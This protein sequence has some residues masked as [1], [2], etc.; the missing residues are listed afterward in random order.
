MSQI[1]V[2]SRVN[3]GHSDLVHDVRF[4][5]F[6][7][8]LATCSSD[9]LIK[10]FQVQKD[11]HAGQT[12]SHVADLKGHEDAVWQV[13]WAFPLHGTVLASC[14]Y[15]R[16]III[17]RQD[18]RQWSIVYEYVHDSPVN[19]ISFAPFDLGRLMLA[20]GASDGTILVLSYQDDG[21]WAMKKIPNA[22]GLGVMAVSWG[23]PFFYPLN[24]KRGDT[25]TARLASGGCDNMVK[26]W[27]ENG[28]NGA[29]PE[30]S[31]LDGH[32]DWVR[33]VA[34]RINRLFEHTTVVSA[35][36]DRKVLIWRHDGHT[37]WT[38]DVLKVFDDVPWTLSFNPTGSSLGVFWGTNS[39]TVFRDSNGQWL[40]ITET[41][42]EDEENL[43]D[44]SGH[45]TTSFSNGSH[46]AAMVNH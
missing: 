33:D 13:S 11:E 23:D 35:S 15:D 25:V 31:R 37:G 1:Q 22:H 9:R 42:S 43:G 39:M 14:G 16:K 24:G 45:N 38:R 27:R 19:C 3:S 6:G 28:D 41:P 17:W 36:Q 5:H 30:E 21:T 44:E 32:T 29:W 10:I 20:A 46:E 7:T 34:W 12:F 8:S 4:D 40:P 26:I 18:G 2:L